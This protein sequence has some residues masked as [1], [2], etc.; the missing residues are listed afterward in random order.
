MYKV[1]TALL[2]LLFLHSSIISI[3]VSEAASLRLMD[4]DGK[5][6]LP[7]VRRRRLVDET[8]VKDSTTR[9][10]GPACEG[11]DYY[12]YDDAVDDAVDDADDDDDDDYQYDDDND[13]NDDDDND[14]DD[15]YESEIST[16]TYNRQYGRPITV[17]YDIPD[18][19]LNK[20]VYIGVFEEISGEDFDDYPLALWSYTCGSQKDKY[21]TCNSG[22]IVFDLESGLELKEKQYFPIR[23]ANY[24]L[25][26]MDETLDYPGKKLH[27][28][29]LKV[30]KIKQEDINDT[31][32]STPDEEYSIDDE[33][34]IIDFSSPE[35]IDGQWI[36][37]ISVHDF[38]DLK[39]ED[40][41]PDK[42]I[43]TWTYSGGCDKDEY[44][45]C[46]KEVDDGTVEI[47]HGYFKY[48]GEMYKPCLIYDM[49]EPYT[50]WKCGPSFKLYSDEAVDD[51]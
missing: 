35:P 38:N 10:C 37:L 32:I 18:D 20:N 9:A 41:L 44:T 48:Y 11:D 24:Q 7:V 25:C 6:P 26:I 45:K 39:D 17:E 15:D 4:D 1:T 33:N 47:V 31:A 46:W 2:F 29:D 49:N 5:K 21:D 16:P 42:E 40:V 14:D 22:T 43:V 50:Q 13:D 34:I 23:P 27:C 19:E 8:V 30:R 12:E 36:G 3:K 51:D 28:V